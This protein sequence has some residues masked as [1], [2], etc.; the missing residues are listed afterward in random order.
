MVELNRV[1]NG[2]KAYAEEEIIAKLSG[3][4]KWVMGAGVSMLLDNGVNTFNALKETEIIKVMEIVNTDNQIDLEKIYK[5]F[6]EQ[7]EKGAIT[8][9]VPL[10][11]SMTINRNDVEKMYNCILRS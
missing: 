7:A 5:A 6:L 10:I 9:K 3:L 8:F 1:I 4:D 2:L 11:G